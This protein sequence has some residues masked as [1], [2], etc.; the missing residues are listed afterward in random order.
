MKNCDPGIK[1]GHDG[2]RLKNSARMSFFAAGFLISA[3]APLV[4]YAKER[5]GIESESTLGFLLLCLGMGSLA[6]M[7]IA[8]PVASRVGCRRTIAFAAAG[9]AVA[10]FFLGVAP[11]IPSLAFSLFLFGAFLGLLDV[12]ANIN[13]IQVQ[14]IVN[15]KLMSGFHSLYSVGGFTGAGTVSVLLY[16][17][18]TPVAATVFAVT[19]VAAL[20]LLWGSGILGEVDRNPVPFFV[21]PKG[22]VL[23]IGGLCFILFLV[24]GAILDWSAVLLTTFHR[25][26]VETAG[27]GYSIFAVAMASARMVG[28]RLVAYDKRTVVIAGCLA[29]AAGLTLVAMSRTPIVGFAAFALVGLG[30]AN[31]VPVLFSEAAQQRDMPVQLSMASVGLMGYAGVLSGPALIGFISH[32]IGLPSTFLLMAVIV[33]APGILAKRVLTTGAAVSTR[34]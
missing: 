28:D 7:L 34:R 19:V 1:P 13:A 30:V 14:A 15:K 24:E 12:T 6:S 22:M 10:L 23:V 18:L 20:L 4:P 3:W 11:S 17:G 5:A 33:L 31:V 8:G 2:R 25:V 21:L 9:A 26:D 27:L 32:V 29:A 16:A